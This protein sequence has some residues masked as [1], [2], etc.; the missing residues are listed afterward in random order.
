V[1]KQAGL[2]SL[3]SLFLLNVNIYANA[4]TAAAERTEEYFSLLANCRI[5]VF[6]NHTGTVGDE[7]LV[8][9]LIRNGFDVAVIFAPEHGFRGDADA[10]ETVGNSIDGRTG[11]PVYS[12][13]GSR[14]RKLD[15][16]TMSKIDILIT[17]IQDVGLRFYTYYITMYYLMEACADAE[18]PML[19]LDR[20]N[21]NGFYVDGPLL[22]RKHRSGV[23]CLPIPVVHGMTLGELAL[24]INGERWLPDG[25]TCKLQVIPCGNYTRNMKYRLPVPPSPNL[26]NMKS[27]WLYPSTCLFEGTKVSLGRG[28]DFPFQV[29]G[30]PSMKGKFSFTPRSKSG[31]KNPPFKNQQ[32]YGEDL[33]NVPDSVV[34]RQGINLQYII[35]AYNNLDVGEKFFTPFFEKLIGVDYVRK[36]IIEGKSADEI[37]A[38]WKEDVEAFKKKR[39][40][41]LLYKDTD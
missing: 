6:S 29:Y 11:V 19:I 41:Y 10:G 7:H 23:G 35:D 38:V 21:P 4:P 24:M 40:K 25:K 31:A 34:W 20:P 5:G 30:S 2:L 16:E 8:D 18:K 37:K 26:P 27:V 22:D 32:C 15:A 33:R 17:D 28:T 9:V 36:M 13:F 12:L 14:N 3:L 1:M 39:E